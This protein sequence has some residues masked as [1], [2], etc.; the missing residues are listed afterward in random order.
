MVGLVGSLR[1]ELK[2]WLGPRKTSLYQVVELVRAR[3]PNV[4]IAMD[5]V[6]LE[7]VM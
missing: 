4:R 2:L 6:I 1:P 3:W 7:D 5:E